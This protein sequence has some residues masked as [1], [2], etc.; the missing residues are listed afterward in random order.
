[1][2]RLPTQYGT[3]FAASYTISPAVAASGGTVQVSWMGPSLNT[4]TAPATFS[5]ATCTLTSSYATVCPLSQASGNTAACGDT[6]SALADVCPGG[7]FF[8][9]GFGPSSFVWYDAKGCTSGVNC[10]SC[11]AHQAVSIGSGPCA[12]AVGNWTATMPTV[13]AKNYVVTYSVTQS[14]ASN[15]G[16]VDM[17]WTATG[18]NTYV[19]AA[20][21]SPSTCTLA[22]TYTA[23]C[24]AAEAAGNG[25]SCGDTNSVGADVCP[26]GDAT[27]GGFSP[28]AVDWWDAQGCSAGLDCA[29]CVEHVATSVLW[30]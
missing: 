7:D 17:T 9:A 29:T 30:N 26:N 5:T 25:N 8:T 28:P 16:T 18:V 19:A 3:E 11:T 15:G 6:N 13:Y 23:V 22:A 4:F 20:T 12:A 10:A 1:V 27:T 2:A 24:A 21:F 14:V